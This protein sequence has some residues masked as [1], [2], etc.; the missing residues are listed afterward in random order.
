MGGKLLGKSINLFLAFYFVCKMRVEQE[1]NQFRFEQ[2]ED[3]VTDF[4]FF[5]RYSKEN[6]KN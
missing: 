1:I 6:F 2:T 3:D 5:N 4:N